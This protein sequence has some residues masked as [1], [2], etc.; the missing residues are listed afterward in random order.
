MIWDVSS[1]GRASALQ[2][3][4]RWFNSSKFIVRTWL[5]NAYKMFFKYHKDGN[6]YPKF[7]RYGEFNTLE[8]DEFV[9]I[10]FNGKRL[11]SRVFGSIGVKIHRKFPKEKIK[12][13]C[14][15][16][17][18]DKW[19]VCFNVEVSVRSAVEPESS[20][21]V[22]LGINSLMVLSTGEKIPSI[23][24][25]RNHEKELRIKKQGVVQV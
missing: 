21:G 23:N 9:G 18:A 7:K 24:E 20:V 17:E 2:A 13:V 3:G 14:I 12:S 16:K 19:Y 11:K 4:G 6:G 8:W 10:Y 25:F 22:D 15:T 1:I 5:D